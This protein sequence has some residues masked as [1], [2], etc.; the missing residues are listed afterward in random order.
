MTYAERRERER[1]SEREGEC[2]CMTYAI[3]V[4]TRFAL[5]FLHVMRRFASEREGERERA[6]EREGECVWCLSFVSCAR[7]SDLVN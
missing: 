5:F 1:E 6:R 4:V 3:S 7:A 2:V